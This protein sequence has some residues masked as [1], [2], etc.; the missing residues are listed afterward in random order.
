MYRIEFSEAGVTQ[1]APPHTS[2]S[3]EVAKRRADFLDAVAP[4]VLAFH[5][6]IKETAVQFH[7]DHPGME[8]EEVL[9]AQERERLDLLW[10]D[11]IRQH[12]ELIA[13]DS[14]RS[15]LLGSISAKNQAVSPDSLELAF[16]REQNHLV[17]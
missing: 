5:D 15:L 16:Q 3:A 12:P 8:P 13:I 7:Q 17:R 2:M 14:N 9:L 6:L 1:I 11:F 10:H 4:V